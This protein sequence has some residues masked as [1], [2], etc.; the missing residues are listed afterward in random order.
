MSGI[1][2]FLLRQPFQPS[3]LLSA[4]PDTNQKGNPVSGLIL[5]S[6]NHASHSTLAAIYDG[7]LMRHGGL[8]ISHNNVVEPEN[9]DLPR[10]LTFR[11]GEG[12]DT[13][14]FPLTP[15]ETEAGY[16]GYVHQGLWPVF[17]QRPDLAHFSAEARRQY[18]K[19]NQAYARAVCEYAMPDDD[20]W[21]QDYHL[22]PTVGLIRDAGLT[23]RIGLFLHQPFPDGQSFQSIPDWQWLASSLLCCDLIGF[24]TVQDM[25]NFLLWS[26][27]VYRVERLSATLFRIHDRIITTGVFPMGIDNADVQGLLE[28]NSCQF[29]EQQCRERL[30]ENLILSGGHLD[31]SAGLPYRINAME[32]L[33]RKHP[34]HAGN[35]TLLQLASPAAGHAGRSQKITHQLESMSG[36]LNGIYGSLEWYPVS[37][38][39]QAFSREEQAGIYRAARVAVVTPLR[40][41]M[42]LMAKMYVALQDPAN[43]GVLILSR[44]A[45]AAEQMDGAIIVNP[46]DAEEIAAA[47]HTA[48]R[49][50]LSVRQ[51]YHQRL[52]KELHLHDSHWWTTRFLSWLSG[53]QSYTEPVKAPSLIL[54]AGFCSRARY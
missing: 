14:T 54:S 42:S 7:I 32:I 46:Y 20:I 19:M 6:H 38:L 43:P 26:E 31:D 10:A 13:L 52:L 53:T 24:Q 37:C 51:D 29:M 35:V 34:E 45:G 11:T 4:T 25:N 12:Y 9:P 3:N 41:G 50:P 18:Q 27:S 47:I 8:W 15:G 30:P 36:E 33:L 16:N 17:H 48:L 28:S 39:A 1:L 2:Q 40:A 5:V 21:I 23:N 22:I 49:L 44:F